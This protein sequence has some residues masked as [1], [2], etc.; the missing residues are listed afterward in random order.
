MK[1]AILF[2]CIPIILLAGLT[3]GGCKK[4][5]VDKLIYQ[6]KYNEAAKVCDRPEGE[7]R[8]ICL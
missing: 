5:D 8:T 3:V 6:G 4:K 7:T 1:P 2:I